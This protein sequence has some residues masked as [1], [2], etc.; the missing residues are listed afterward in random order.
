MILASTPAEEDAALEELRVAQRADFEEILEAMDGLPVTIRLLDPPLH[1][2]LPDTEELA[3]KEATV[4]LTDEEGRLYEA[5][6][7]W[8]EY[9]PM[10]GT[11]GVRLGVIKPGLYA[12][13]VR[14]LMEAA[15]DRV[16]CRR[17]PDRRDHDPPHRDPRGDGPGPL[18]GWRRRC[19]EA[20]A[21]GV[22]RRAE[23]EDG[24]SPSSHGLGGRS[25]CSSAP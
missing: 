20:L 14:A 5:A 22:D 13:Q 25:R 6:K 15:L 2:F 19:A 16:G 1:E 9:N 7:T 18:A 4:G 23:H 17:P 8:H 11:R 3:I 12:M 21:A 10:L 24:G